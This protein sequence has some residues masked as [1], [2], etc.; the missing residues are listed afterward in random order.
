MILDIEDIKK[1]ERPLLFGDSLVA[2]MP[3]SFDYNNQGIAG[4]TAYALQFILEERVVMHNPTKAALHIGAND[5][6]FTVMSS[7]QEIANTVK[8][9]FEELMA[10]LPDTKFYLISTLPCVDEFDNSIGLTSGNKM[11]GFHDELNLE[12][13]KQLKGMDIEHINLNQYLRNE[14]GSVKKEHYK[15]HLHIK[16]EAYDYLYQSYQESRNNAEKNT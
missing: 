12:Y 6:R 9:I 1:T 4:L 8:L 14:D 10:D 2:Y 3:D 11:N 16:D 7:P 5:L 13:K 15:D